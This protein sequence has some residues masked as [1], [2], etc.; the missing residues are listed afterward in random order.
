MSIFADL[1]TKTNEYGETISIRH[2]IVRC[3]GL[4][5]ARLGQMVYFENGAMGYIGQLNRNNVEI[6][7]L[8]K[9]IVEPLEK[10]VRTDNY[11]EFEINTGC[12]G[13]VLDPLGNVLYGGK[14]ITTQK[15][16][17]VIVNQETVPDI[18]KRSK[19]INQLTTGLAIIDILLPLGM[20]QRELVVGSRKTGKTYAAM[21]IAMN[22]AKI[23]NVVIFALVGK[24]KA[25]IKRIYELL[26]ETDLLKNVI[27]VA[28]SSDDSPALIE[29]TPYVA[30]STAEYFMSQG[31][32]VLVLL[33]DLTTHAQV[34]REMS[35]LA[36]R[37][38]GRDS[39]PGDIF[40]KHAQLLERAGAFKCQN[41][42]SGTATIS[43]L[44]IAESIQKR[45]SDYIISNLIG[46]TDGH[47]LFD[48]ESF[49]QGRRPA[50]E[51]YL[52]VTRVGKQTQSKIARSLNRNLYK[53]MNKYKEANRF[54]HFGAELNERAA[55]ILDRGEKVYTFFTQEY[56]QSIPY[57]AQ[58]IILAM[59]INGLLDA[60][61]M[62]DFV[63]IR[64]VF[65]QNYLK[66]ENKK[67]IDEIVDSVTLYDELSKKIDENG[68]Y[69]FNLC[70]I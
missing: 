56:N 67:K 46:I 18:T 44:A 69:F 12:L 8:S 16:V 11:I 39:Y 33:D 41:A 24:Q 29:L 30:M 50:I 62:D 68:I 53:L 4:P 32:D 54:R 27:V 14:K 60:V 1:L 35:L 23:G 63:K 28:T 26:K 52:S 15:S 57:N 3:S 47:L 19:I 48:E 58:I 10:C 25:E 22:Q 36:G 65:I 6:Q 5:N 17:K 2:P 31:R 61:K 38:P 42:P 43:C 49:N 45:L 64:G 21:S 13:L 9:Q 20:G 59:I 70:T 51:I 55:R 40:Y 37:F 66:L 7:I 34:H